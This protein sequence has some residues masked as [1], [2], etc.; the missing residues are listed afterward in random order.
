MA[1][2]A[3]PSL[4]SIPSGAFSL[5]VNGQIESAYF[6]GMDHLYCK[7][8]FTNGPDW[9]L[10]SGLE[11][12][13]TQMSR[14]STGLPSTKE[15]IP[16]N[17]K[18]CVFNFPIEIA[19][20]S[21]NAFGWPQMVL[22]VYGLD[23]MGR[24]VVRGYGSIRLPLSPG[25]FTK[26]VPMFVPVSSSALGG[27][28][29]W[30]TGQL[31]EFLDPKFV[32]TNEGREVTRVRSQG[33]VRVT[34][35]VMVKDLVYNLA[36]NPPRTVKGSLYLNGVRAWKGI[37]YAAQPVGPLRFKPPSPPTNLTNN[38]YIA[39]SFGAA[40]AQKSG[41]L[42]PVIDEACLFLNIYAPGNIPANTV[43][44]VMVWIHGGG[45]TTGS[46][47]AP[48]SGEVLVNHA[49]SPVVVVTINYRLNVFGFL[50][51]SDLL[52]QGATNIGYLDQQ[53]AFKWVQKYIRQFGGDPY[54]ITA[55]GESAGAL[56]IGSHLIASNGRQTMFH[57]AILESGSSLSGA[58]FNADAPV[59]TST[60]NTIVANAGCS[61][62]A[63]KINCLRT[64]KWQ[65]LFAAIPSNASFGPV[66]DELYLNNKPRVAFANQLFSKI[67]VIIGTNT[68][69]GTLFVPSSLILSFSQTDFNNWFT[70]SLNSQLGPNVASALST[71]STLYPLS[72]YGG[73]A[74]S[75]AATVFGDAGFAC[76]ARA[77]LKAYAS[78]GVPAWKY[79]FN[80]VITEFAA[81]QP[82]FGVFHAAELPLVWGTPGTLLTPLELLLSDAMM[83]RWTNFA[84]YGDPN[85]LVS[86][87]A[88]WPQYTAV[89]G[90]Q[91]VFQETLLGFTNELDNLRAA[92]CDFWAT[93]NV[94]DH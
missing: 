20:K 24:D 44:P 16:P 9:V 11:E 49:A 39:T 64:L 58:Y 40:C 82:I 2:T 93:T 89:N 61:K 91:Q 17:S 50:A 63:D 32:A 31:P 36:S 60:Y 47:G 15:T 62:A 46:G 87:G 55:F 23:A 71:V 66:I 73:S 94:I 74:F 42:T 78:A 80:Q 28:L 43:Y 27:F 10:L 77:V 52:A 7:F 4:P 51:G 85:G 21:T 65:D 86:N 29:S 37:P 13:I 56:S 76:P 45:D 69:E 5:V 26:E 72:S 48:F 92:Q 75:A 67:P 1:A 70:Q 54:S 57:R 81:I 88:N 19:F 83:K 59:P 12:G 30:A 3:A 35:N 38:P 18:I 33:T 34:F 22:S 25:R 84:V 53:F 14:K 68:N 41:I 90:K 6:P 79:R 8:S